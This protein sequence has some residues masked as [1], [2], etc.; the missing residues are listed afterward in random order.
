M[1]KLV[2]AVVLVVAP[3]SSVSPQHVH[4]TPQSP[5]VSEVMQ[6]AEEDLDA[7]LG[8]LERL[9]T[10]GHDEA[11]R[12]EAT[13]CLVQLLATKST[14]AGRAA[15][16][17]MKLEAHRPIEEVEFHAFEIAL[18]S[19]HRQ[20]GEHLL[21][22]ARAAT[23]QHADSRAAWVL[24]ASAASQQRERSLAID[25]WRKA[26]AIKRTVSGCQR[27]AYSLYN[28]GLFEETIEVALA[29]PE[30]TAEH[31]IRLT[32]FALNELGREDEAR[33]LA[34]E[35]GKGELS[36]RELRV[37]AQFFG[38]LEA[39]DERVAALLRAVPR[40]A[41]ATEERARTY[42][43]L[44]EAYGEIGD[45]ANAVT[46]HKLACRG[47]AW[48]DRLR[49]A[50]Y[51]P[52]Y[53]DDPTELADVL[54]ACFDGAT[55]MRADVPRAI[56]AAA[57][58]FDG[59]ARW[60]ADVSR[61]IVVA[62]VEADCLGGLTAALREMCQA[63][64]A[65][66][67]E[68][69]VLE[70]A[71]LEVEDATGAAT[72]TRDLHGLAPHVVLPVDVA[73]AYERAGDHETAVE[74]FERMDHL[75]WPEEG[76]RAAGR[77][78]AA[79]NR[80]ERLEEIAEGIRR[81]PHNAVYEGILWLEAGDARRA[82]PLLEGIR[83]G[84]DRRASR[85]LLRAYLALERRDDAVGALASLLK[86]TRSEAWPSDVQTLARLV[87]EGSE[88]S[89]YVP[90]M[91]SAL[92]GVGAHVAVPLKAAWVQTIDAEE[93]AGRLP[94][95]TSALQAARASSPEDFGCCMALAL[96]YMRADAYAEAKEAFDEAIR[97]GRGA[98]MAVQEEYSLA[99]DEA[100]RT[101]P[102]GVLREA[103]AAF[104]E[105]FGPALTQ[106][107]VA[108]AADLALAYLACLDGSRVPD[109]SP[110]TG[111]CVNRARAT[112][113]LE[114]FTDA[115]S[116]AAQEGDV[117]GG[118]AMLL[119]SCYH[120]ARQ[121]DGVIEVL[122]DHQE[123]IRQDPSAW[124]MLA[125]AGERTG[126][127]EVVELAYGHILEL[128]P[129]DWPRAVKLAEV[130]VKYGR[131]ADAEGWCDIA[132]EWVETKGADPRVAARAAQYLAEAGAGEKATAAAERALEL[133]P[134]SG[135]AHLHVGLAYKAL[136]LWKEAAEAWRKA[137]TLE[138]DPVNAPLVERLLEEAEARGG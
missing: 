50:Q 37:L 44:A 119:A 102:A 8:E 20:V 83:P 125:N 138:Q 46:Y 108:R 116:Q 29:T 120:S 75:N 109:R 105:Q 130:Y 92:V 15:A 62:A 58:A 53:L 104:R 52:R 4:S 65:T 86:D 27:L 1:V 93:Q 7:A 95:L 71:C 3:V 16:V 107:D 60:Q 85:D 110:V 28:A 78:Y 21:A 137:L 131:D 48:I 127:L 132:L 19:Q 90:R 94:E 84:P 17:L 89:E 23:E 35:V 66:F 5:A 100:K 41:E 134:E 31:R 123:A 9:A 96:V 30:L 64:G 2:G 70:Q 40:D 77:S 114:A 25:G 98:S 97:R 81:A 88:P 99:S 33:A 61:A 32:G 129:D 122:T 74:H 22:A 73:V 106:G 72:A 121:Y 11:E 117:T 14:D 124:T 55:R 101:S 79:L 34:D 12:G 135:T 24:L 113:Q 42:T 54:D 136:G 103:D 51:V 18:H 69:S 13:G 26:L 111:T 91:V 49:L 126:N 82:L 39:H 47:G 80:P 68:L 43:A 115:V 38:R 87:R 59:V 118:H 63:R 45:G 128:D 76:Y 112:K 6:Q 57:V 10:S 67:A 56:V 133:G 36:G